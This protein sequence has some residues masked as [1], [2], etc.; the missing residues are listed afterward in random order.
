MRCFV[1]GDADA[2]YGLTDLDC[3]EFLPNKSP[4]PIPTTNRRRPPLPRSSK[5]GSA[6]SAGNPWKTKTSRRP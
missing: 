3:A 1:C 6:T 2:E 5:S 4:L